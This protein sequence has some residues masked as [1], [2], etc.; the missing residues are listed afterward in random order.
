MGRNP[1]T[2]LGAVI[3]A[4][5]VVM[6]NASAVLKS[7]STTRYSDG[8]L[9]AMHPLPMRRRPCQTSEGNLGT[10]EVNM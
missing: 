9:G 5:R 8:C 6:F 4:R 1:K 10:D 3:D 2:G 7:A